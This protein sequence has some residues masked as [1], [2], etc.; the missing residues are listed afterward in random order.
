MKCPTVQRYTSSSAT[1]LGWTFG[2]FPVFCYCKSSL[3]E[4]SCSCLLVLESENS[5]EFTLV[6]YDRCETNHHNTSGLQQHGFIISQLWNQKSAWVSLGWSEAFVR[7]T[8]PLGSL[9][10]NP[11]PWGFSFLASRSHLHSLACG[12]SLHLQSRQH[13]VFKFLWLWPFASIVTA[14]VAPTLTARFVRTLVI[15]WGGA[16][17]G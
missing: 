15:A 4:H 6:S 13:S 17:G 16:G 9:W 10:E 1:T 5:Q 14:S 3:C 12:S 8:V 7:V 2:L 11:F